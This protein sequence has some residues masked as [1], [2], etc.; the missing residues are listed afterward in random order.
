MIPAWRSAINNNVY[1]STG[2]AR[3]AAENALVSNWKCSNLRSRRNK[4]KKGENILHEYAVSSS[5]TSKTPT[6]LGNALAKIAA[7]SMML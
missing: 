2:R 6:S 1:K 4:M 7:K 3:A 5:T